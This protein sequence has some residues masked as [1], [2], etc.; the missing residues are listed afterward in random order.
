MKIVF[1]SSAIGH[2]EIAHLNQVNKRH[3]NY[4]QQKWDYTF[5]TALFQLLK[6]DFV[7]ISY[8]SVSAF[9]KYSS[10]LY[11]K[12]IIMEEINTKCM[13]IMNLPIIKQ[14][15]WMLQLKRELK[16]IVKKEGGVK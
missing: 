5:S 13:G 7:G 15:V 1:I 6:S 16:K 12:P 10:E 8:P 4:V 11:S 2:K 14:L 9:P 3:I